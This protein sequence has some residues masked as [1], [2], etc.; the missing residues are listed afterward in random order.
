MYINLLHLHNTL[1]WVIL[2][3]AAIVLIRS[4]S[5]WFGKK[6]WGKTDTR[7]G[8]VF[9]SVFYLQ[10]L[11]GFALYAF[12]SPLLK[13]A[14]A[15]FG[16]AMKNAEL[17]FIAVEHTTMMVFALILVH[18]GQMKSKKANTYTKKHRTAAIFYSIA[19]ILILIAIPW[20]RL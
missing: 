20:G 10:F 4:Y 19:T 7:L 9:S 16:A 12:Y 17:R 11:I 15:D 6:R 18:L 2:I 8:L 13:I 5:G 14:F 3:V 1:R